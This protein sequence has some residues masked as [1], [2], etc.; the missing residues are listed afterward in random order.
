MV[1]PVDVFQGGEGGVVKVSPGSPV[2]DQFSFVE[3]D[4]GLCQGIVKAV[5]FASHRCHDLTFGQPVGIANGQILLRFK[6]SSQQ[7]LV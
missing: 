7:C 6:G 3:T 4:G 5:S 2:A 1:E